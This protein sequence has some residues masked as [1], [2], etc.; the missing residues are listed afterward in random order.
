M[1]GTALTRDQ[2]KVAYIDGSTV[3][4]GQLREGSQPA[5]SDRR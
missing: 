2:L 3:L 4:P 5:D 1:L